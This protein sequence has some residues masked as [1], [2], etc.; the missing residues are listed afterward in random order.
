MSTPLP[1]PKRVAV[2]V[3]DRGMCVYCGAAYQ[4][5]ARLTVD[6]VVSR[7][8]G[9]GGGDGF[10]NLVTCAACNSDKSHFSLGA[11]LFELADRGASKTHTEAIAA[12]V[13]AACKAPIVWPKVEVALAIYREQSELPFADDDSD[14]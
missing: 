14:D 10:D 2:F 6:H 3:R 4:A 12:R 1:L 9:G 5:G 11:Y 8:R 7:K 13:G